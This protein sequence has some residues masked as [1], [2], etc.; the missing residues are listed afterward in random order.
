MR[1]LAASPRL[2]VQFGLF[3]SRALV[4]PDPPRPAERLT[5][6]PND[7]RRDAADRAVAS[8]RSPVP[9]LTEDFRA[10]AE[11]APYNPLTA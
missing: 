11:S 4:D 6:P 7:A 8:S 5:G 3:T 1:T 10:V 9:T 2:P